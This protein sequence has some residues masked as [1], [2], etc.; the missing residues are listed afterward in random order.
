MPGLGIATFRERTQ[1]DQWQRQI[2]PSGNHLHRLAVH[3][4]KARPE[5]LVSPHDLVQA[6]PQGVKI[7]TSAQAKHL[8]H[9]VE[10]VAGFELLQEPH[11]LLRERQ[12][13]WTIAPDTRQ[14][15]PARALGCLACRID[16]RCQRGHGRGIEQG[17]HWQFDRERLAQA[18]HGLGGQ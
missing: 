10:R 2:E 17:A 6:L 14:G 16:Q 12:Q 5:R 8:R 11:T 18:A 13:Q 3:A 9:V 4:G 1:I 7:E 15:Q